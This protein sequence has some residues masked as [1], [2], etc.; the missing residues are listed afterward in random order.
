MQNPTH[1]NVIAFMDQFPQE[2]KLE[3]YIDYTTQFNKAYL[4]PIEGVLEAIGWT[5]E[6]QVELDF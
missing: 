3:K 6:Q 2:I 1:E 4:A 5:A